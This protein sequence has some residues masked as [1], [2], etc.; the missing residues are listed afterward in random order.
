MWVKVQVLLYQQVNVAV[1]RLRERSL[2]VDTESLVR[3]AWRNR[4]QI[5]RWLLVDLYRII[6]SRPSWSA[7]AKTAPTAWPLASVSRMN[8]L[9]SFERSVK[10]RIG[11]EVRAIFMCSKLKIPPACWAVNRPIVLACNFTTKFLSHLRLRFSKWQY[12]S[13]FNVSVLTWPRCMSQLCVRILL[14]RGIAKHEW[15]RNISF[16]ATCFPAY[17]PDNVRFPNGVCIT[18][19]WN[20]YLR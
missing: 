4:L 5:P 2:Y 12:S 17:D 6:R 11:A 9:A 10:V 20:L 19:S 14:L 15:V 8:G 7:C 18:C 1:L 13:T 16:K 3:V